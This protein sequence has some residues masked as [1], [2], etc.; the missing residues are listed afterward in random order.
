M[1]KRKFKTLSADYMYVIL[2]YLVV[3]VALVVV[4]MAND[5]NVKKLAY[6]IL[7]IG[8]VI[9]MYSFYTLYRDQRLYE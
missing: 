4:A 7:G 8:A 9:L 1:N 3:A 2:S 6:S 5:I